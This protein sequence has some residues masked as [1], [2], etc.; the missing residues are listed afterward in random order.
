[1]AK[2]EQQRQK[3]L[4]K[5]RAKKHVEHREVAR[6]NQLMTSLAGQAQWASRFPIQSCLVSEES[7][8]TMGLRTVYLTRKVGEG[9]LACL[10]VLVDIYCLGVKNAG[11]RFCAPSELED[12][13][14]KLSQDQQFIKRD[15]SYARKLIEQA[16][17]YADSLGF[18]AH[19]DYRK[20][21][22]FWGDV[23]VSQCDQEFT[24]GRDGQP[25]YFAGPHE[26]LA[27]QRA[28]Y[29]RLCETAGEGNFHFVLG[30]VTDPSDLSLARS[31]GELRFVDGS[32]D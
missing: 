25:F 17:I 20:T 12:L 21:L 29:N 15:P 26:D 13:F 19:P 28:I 11:F 18:S 32:H 10:F 7:G 1:M 8:G 23:D 3:K 5:K 27:K 14:K 6:R 24:F 2:S 9:R 31:G 4:A 22:S 16:V 30:G